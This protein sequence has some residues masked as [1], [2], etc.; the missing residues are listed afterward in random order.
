MLESTAVTTLPSDREPEQLELAAEVQRQPAPP[1]SWQRMRGLLHPSHRHSVFS[2]TVVLMVSTFLSRII[3]LVR[4][5]YI[6]WLFGRGVEAD[7]FNAAF[8]L[9]DMISYFLVGGAASITFVTILTRYREA[10][11]RSRGRAFALRHSYHH[12]PGAGRGHRAGRNLRPLVRAL[13]VQ[14]IRS[15]KRPRSASSSP[16]FC[17][18]R[19]CASLPAASLARCCW[20]ASNSACRPSRRSSTASAPSSAACCWSS[21]SA[22]LRWPSARWPEPSVGPFLL[23]WYLRAPRRHALSLYSRLARRGPARVGPSVPAADGRRLAGHRRQLDHRPLRVT[24]RRRS[25]ADELRQAA[26]HRAHGHAGPGR[27]RCLHAFLRQPLDARSPLRIRH[28]RR[29]FSLPRGRARPSRRFH[30]GG[31]RLAGHR[32]GLYRRPI[33]ARRCAPVRLLF[34]HLLGFAFSLVR[35]GHL[36]R[37]PSTPPETPSRPWSP[38]PSS[39]SSH[40]PSTSCS[41]TGVAPWAWRSH[42]M[43]ASCCRRSPSLCFCTSAAWFRSPASI[44]PS[45]AVVCWVLLPEAEPRGSSPGF[46]PALFRQV[47]RLAQLHHARSIA[48]TA[49]LIGGFAVWTAVVMLVLDKSGSALPRVVMRR[50]HS[51]EFRQCMV[52]RAPRN[53]PACSPITPHKKRKRSPFGG[54]A[55][56][57]CEITGCAGQLRTTSCEPHESTAPDYATATG[58]DVPVA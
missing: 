9:P 40:F 31:A 34:R 10:G 21:A 7:A 42:P 49:I 36:L 14:R 57:Q 43:S 47:P 29:R 54:S 39:P 19:S 16:A 30:H 11:P 53:W 27:R 33:F 2:A 17:C 44:M 23:N 32:S 50:L 52:L 6:V 35:A 48:D 1:S 37:A 45:W 26:F 22:S 55:Y 28:R 56:V 4:V 25:F 58:P 46:L 18:P 12:V 41:F 24:D 38:A 20:C 51:A 5:K 3:G 8:V 13:V 15:R